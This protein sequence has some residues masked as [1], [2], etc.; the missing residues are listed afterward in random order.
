MQEESSVRGARIHWRA[1]TISFRGDARTWVPEEAGRIA[2]N[3][4]EWSTDLCVANQSNW[5][6]IGRMMNRLSVP[7]PPLSTTTPP[8]PRCRCRFRCLFASSAPRRSDERLWDPTWWRG[9]EWGGMI[10]IIPW[11]L[12]QLADRTYCFSANSLACVIRCFRHL[13]A[14]GSHHSQ[15]Q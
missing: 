5:G 10:I 6:A 4:M 12:Q 15:Q 1:A 14:R 9:G 2:M 3:P 13:F 11:S 7:L 8:P